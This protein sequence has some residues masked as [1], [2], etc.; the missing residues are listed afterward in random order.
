MAMTEL[1]GA[2]AAGSPNADLIQAARLQMDIV[3]R[4]RGEMPN[5]LAHRAAL[6]LTSA[7]EPSVDA[8]AS[9]AR[10]RALTPGRFDYAFIEAQ[11]LARRGEFAAA[12]TVS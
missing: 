2:G 8:R 3:Q 4:D 5:V 7:D 12:R 11:I 6:E 10:A 9:I 1:A